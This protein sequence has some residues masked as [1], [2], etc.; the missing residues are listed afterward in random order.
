VGKLPPHKPRRGE[1]PLIRQ[2]S[3]LREPFVFTNKLIATIATVAPRIDDD[4]INIS[5]E[6]AQEYSPRRKPWVS[7]RQTKPQNGAKDL[8]PTDALTACYECPLLDPL[9]F[10][11]ERIQTA[12][13]RSGD[14]IQPTAQAVGSFARDKPHGGERI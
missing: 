1:R 4:P 2:F 14:R 9:S 3:A 7:W 12:Q 5:R 8:N 10:L 13:P 11:S 6:A